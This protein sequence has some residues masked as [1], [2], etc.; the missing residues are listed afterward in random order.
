MVKARLVTM[1]SELGARTSHGAAELSSSPMMGWMK[2]A[3]EV[4][5]LI[6]R[7][8]VVNTL[9]TQSGQP[10]V[11]ELPVAWPGASAMRLYVERREEGPG[12]HGNGPRP[13]RIVTMLEL[14][15]IGP[16]RVDAVFTG[17]KVT[18][19]VLVERSDVGRLVTGMLPML[20]EGLTAQ[21]F[22]VEGLSAS[23]AEPAHVRGEELDVKS[24]P[25]RRLL[26]VRA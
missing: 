8:Q 11:F 13:Y 10:L 12:R 9:N 26:N 21:G 22:V 17:K 24:V 14:P 15:E 19:R 3:Q 20:H 7:T 2:E 5:K 16:I 1:L 4:L 23:V 25:H 6:E 18:G